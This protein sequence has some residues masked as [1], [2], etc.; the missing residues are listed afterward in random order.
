[1]NPFKITRRELLTSAAAIAS[2][3]P[4]QARAIDQQRDALDAWLRRWGPELPS[5][6]RALADM[7][8]ESIQQEHPATWYRMNFVHAIDFEPGSV[9]LVYGFGRISEARAS[10]DQACASID[11][12][13][14]Q[15]LAAGWSTDRRAWTCIVAA[16]CQHVAQL[17]DLQRRGSIL[18][19]YANDDE[20]KEP[21]R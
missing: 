1:M 10:F 6:A 3:T 2:A 16:G 11:A 8:R 15:T 4:N 20:I 19:W 18:E 9:C 14:I 5:M 21:K 12:A 13:G 7:E 17:V